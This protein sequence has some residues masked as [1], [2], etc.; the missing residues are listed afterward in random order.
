MDKIARAV[1]LRQSTMLWDNDSGNSRSTKN[2]LYAAGAG[3]RNRR[4][5]IRP[6][7]LLRENAPCAD[8]TGRSDIVSD[9]HRGT[10]V[11][12]SLMDLIAID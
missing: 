2:V 11:L 8:E 1:M 10:V 7:G 3:Y 12:E 4:Q 6:R 5:K 9:V